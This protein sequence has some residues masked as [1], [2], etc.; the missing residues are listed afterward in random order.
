MG[1]L[2]HFNVIGKNLFSPYPRSSLVKIVSTAELNVEAQS[3]AQ[4]TTRH[5]VLIDGL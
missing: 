4:M 2:K 1:H 5:F 3:V